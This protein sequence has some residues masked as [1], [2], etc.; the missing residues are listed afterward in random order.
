[1]S[2]MRLLTSIDNKEKV[3]KLLNCLKQI[4]IFVQD[5]SFEM[6]VQTEVCILLVL[7]IVHTNKNSH[8][9]TFLDFIIFLPECVSDVLFTKVVIHI[10]SC[11]LGSTH[12]SF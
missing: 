12:D 3:T 2:P 4:T 9:D 8:D 11:S 10:I 1:M 7:S 6:S 5:V